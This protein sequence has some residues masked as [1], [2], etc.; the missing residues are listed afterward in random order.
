MPILIQSLESLI[1]DGK[2][3]TQTYEFI[4]EKYKLSAARKKL[5]SNFF[6]L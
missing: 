1:Y 3:A 2:N 6:K 4:N 5:F